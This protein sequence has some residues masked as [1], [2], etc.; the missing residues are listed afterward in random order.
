MDVILVAGQ[1]RY[2]DFQLKNDAANFNASGMTVSGVLR[3]VA[4]TIQTLS[5]CEVV[6]WL[7]A[8][9]SQVRYAPTSSHFEPAGTPYSLRF[10]V[11]DASSRINYYP[12]ETELNVSVLRQ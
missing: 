5:S 10:R 2:L 8:T 9:C 1:T 12:S 11:I 7:W 3:D 4:G 6:T